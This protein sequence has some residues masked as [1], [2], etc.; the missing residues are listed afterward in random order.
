MAAITVT[1]AGLNLMRDSMNGNNSLKITYVAIGSSTTAPA[2][3][4]TKLGNETFRKKIVNWTNGAS[5]GEALVNGYLNSNDAVGLNL[6][7][8][9][10]FAG[11]TATATVN[12]GILVAHGLFAHGTKLSSEGI[13]LTFDLTF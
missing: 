6:Q 7:E 10:F 4:D 13:Q 12:S 8:V 5:V 1:N 9:G 11:N 2:V 3:T